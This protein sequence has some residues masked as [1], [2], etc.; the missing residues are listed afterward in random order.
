M[1][2]VN[3]QNTLT[4]TLPCQF[5]PLSLTTISVLTAILFLHHTQ[6]TQHHTVT[7]SLQSSPPTWSQNR[8]FCF[9]TQC[10]TLIL[11]LIFLLFSELL[12]LINSA[13]FQ[14]AT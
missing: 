1:L 2:H 4:I 9:H 13:N 3:P 7:W 5:S 10:L 11:T 6:P 14:A 8:Q 12:N